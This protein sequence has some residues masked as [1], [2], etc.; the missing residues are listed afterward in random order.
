MVAASGRKATRGAAQLFISQSKQNGEV[1]LTANRLILIVED[2][3]DDELLA[4]DALRTT[5]TP[6]K[7][8][9]TR[10]GVEALD[11]L[12]ADGAYAGRDQSLQPSLVLL[13]LKLPKLSG[14]D[15]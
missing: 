9:V 1:C 5:R 8:V 15:V 14:F 3:P 2:N 7:V 10:D 4:L 13:D 6:C 11:Y 12:F